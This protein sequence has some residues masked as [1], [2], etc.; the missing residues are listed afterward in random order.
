M[1][2]ATRIRYYLSGHDILCEE[3]V[4]RDVVIKQCIELYKKIALHLSDISY[5]E[6]MNNDIVRL[7]GYKVNLMKKQDLNGVNLWNELDKRMYE[8]GVLTERKVVELLHEVPLCFLMSFVG[9]ASYRERVTD[10]L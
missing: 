9:Y 3:D 2:L 4:D 7:I 6:Y 10:I 1:T 5:V 8:N